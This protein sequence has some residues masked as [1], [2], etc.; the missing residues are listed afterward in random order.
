MC[1]DICQ[2]STF[3]KLHHHPKFILDKEAVV[4]FD[5]IR[6]LVIAHYHNLQEYGYTSNQIMYFESV[7]ELAGEELKP[8][9]G[10]HK[11]ISNSLTSLKSS[12]LR[13]CFLKSIR[14]TATWLP[15]VLWVAMHTIPVEPSPILIKFSKVDLGSPGDTT[16]W[17]AALNCS[18][19]RLGPDGGGA[20]GPSVTLTP[21][22]LVG[23]GR[24]GDGVTDTVIPSDVDGDCF[25]GGWG[26]GGPG[27]RS[28]GFGYIWGGN[29]GGAPP[30]PVG[31]LTNGCGW[32]CWGRNCCCCCW[33]AW[34][35]WGPCGCRLGGLGCLGGGCCWKGGWP[36]PL[37]DTIAPLMGGIS[38][39]DDEAGECW[40][41]KLFLLIIPSLCC[42]TRA[43][44]RLRLLALMALGS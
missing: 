2:S 26:G 20:G 7:L 24:G 14:F 40:D 10:I 32:C 35:W 43:S 13:C 36:P 12:S 15:L 37:A 6:M 8:P 39:D 5:D 11:Y 4:H 34:A 38:L 17:R 41:G 18:W 16:I 3:Q 29:G 19:D 22:P 31:C 28:C 44:A 42:W 25:G 9:L 30:E 23:G 21:L 33:T 27:I 1:D